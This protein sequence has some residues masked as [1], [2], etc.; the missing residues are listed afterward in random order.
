MCKEIDNWT[1]SVMIAVL[2][3][4]VF[5]VIAC[6][7]VFCK[8][9]TTDYSHTEQDRK[10]CAL[11]DSLRH[12][13]TQLPE[14]LE[15]AATVGT[16]KEVQIIYDMQ[17]TLM[18]R[19][20][21]LA[22]DLRQESNN[23]IN[24]TNGWLAFWIAVV[25]LLG[26]IIPGV[27]NFKQSRD[28]KDAE[29]EVRTKIAQALKDQNSQLEARIRKLD[30][31]EERMMDRMENELDKLADIEYT[32]AIRNFHYIFDAPNLQSVQERSHLLKIVCKEIIDGLEII[33]RRYAK[34]PSVE[35]ANALAV[36]LA[37]LSTILPIFRKVSPHKSK[38]PT[39]LQDRVMRLLPVLLSPASAEEREVETLQLHLTNLISTLHTLQHDL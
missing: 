38:R 28:L 10:F 32:K 16:Y 18:A 7:T 35:N 15:P 36:A 12:L 1:H 17:L 39:Q 23:L 8:T 26:V 13:N 25:A 3:C 27:L 19:Q 33:N 29:S 4:T 2:G 34:N 14:L 37:S 22:D 9:C 20:D 5:L 21:R 11:T 31:T 6:I 30:K 24:K